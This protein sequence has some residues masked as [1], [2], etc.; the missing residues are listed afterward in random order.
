[1]ATAAEENFRPHYFK[2]VIIKNRHYNK[3]REEPG[4]RKF[5][6]I[7][8]VEADARNVKTGIMGLGARRM[9]IIEIEDCD[10][11]TFSATI[12]EL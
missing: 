7:E 4:Y 8:Q 12:R 1:M 6:D 10:Y 5:A 3:L 11:K 9:D 2:W